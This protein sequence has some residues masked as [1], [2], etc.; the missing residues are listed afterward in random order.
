MEKTLKITITEYTREDGL[1]TFW[2][3]YPKRGKGW[4]VRITQSPVRM[5]HPQDKVWY[6]AHAISD[7]APY[8]MTEAQAL[9]LLKTLEKPE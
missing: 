2:M 8:F 6:V 4:I 9:D 1:D 5:Y 7:W 3:D